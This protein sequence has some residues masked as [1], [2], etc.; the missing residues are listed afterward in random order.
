MT[1]S[2]RRPIAS[3]LFMPATSEKFIL[4]ARTLDIDAVVL[5][6]EDA[7]AP[8]E[9]DKARQGLKESLAKFSGA[10]AQCFVR[11]NGPL[12]PWFHADLLAVRGT[13][14]I[15]GLVIP[16]VESPR[17]LEIAL[18]LAGWNESRAGTIIAGIETLPGITELHSI[19]SGRN[20]DALYYGSED[21]SADLGLAPSIA[22][23]LAMMR[24]QV[25]LLA[26]RFDA[27]A[28]D[29]GV[30]DVRNPD[31]FRNDAQVGKALGYTGKICLTPAQVEL[32]QAVFRPS[33]PDLAWA[34]DVLA[35]FDKALA[36]GQGVGLVGSMFIDE[37]A[38]RRAR[39][40]L[41]LADVEKQR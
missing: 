6:L 34:R 12:T 15:D 20:V 10:K 28:I 31:N 37:A 4:K 30:A 41:S 26:R 16:K 11:V 8:N 32:A 39:R 22:P 27:L 17:D 33:E 23:N 36:T 40:I 7:I 18:S 24:A 21:L 2:A 19:L 1:S 14:G 3:L 38:A 5:D 35:T 29:Q 25:A 9:K 13:L